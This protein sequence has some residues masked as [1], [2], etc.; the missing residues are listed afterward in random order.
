MSYMRS[1]PQVDFFARVHSIG[2]SGEAYD[3]HRSQRNHGSRQ[4]SLVTRNTIAD[5]LDAETHPT[6]LLHYLTNS[7]SSKGWNG[8]FAAGIHYDRA[9][10]RQRA[11]EL[12]APAEAGSFLRVLREFSW[13]S[14]AA[15]RGFRHAY[16]ALKRHLEKQWPVQ[17]QH[18]LPALPGLDCAADRPREDHS[19]PQTTRSG[20]RNF[21]K[22]HRRHRL[23]SV[24]SGVVFTSVSCGTPRYSS[25]CCATSLNTGADTAAP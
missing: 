19:G 1:E 24:V 8:D 16:L 9:L 21:P 13:K 18:F 7:Q 15:R 20:R 22:A 17:E 6:R 11:P 12:R 2:L 5:K 25:T 23:Q 3:N 10:W 4:R 14:S